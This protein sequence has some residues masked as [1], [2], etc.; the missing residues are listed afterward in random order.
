MED[1]EGN[2]NLMRRRK[3]TLF[4]FDL[5]MVDDDDISISDQEPIDNPPYPVK[6]YIPKTPP[7]LNKVFT[8]P[9]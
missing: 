2:P 1:H 5:A 6:S 3:N 4:S 8:M 9:N 7:P